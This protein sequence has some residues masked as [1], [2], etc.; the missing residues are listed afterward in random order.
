MLIS[1]ARI[2]NIVSSIRISNPFLEHEFLHK[3]DTKYLY[4]SSV[5]YSTFKRQII[6]RVVRYK[7]HQKIYII[8]TNTERNNS[9]AEQD[10]YKSACPVLTLQHSTFQDKHSILAV[11]FYLCFCGPASVPLFR[12]IP[13][14]L[15]IC[16]LACY[17]ID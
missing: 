2:S 1:I 9:F 12:K 3:V 13:L 10:I 16:P 14:C 8:I 6:Y 4:I 7:A 5:S 11:S 15:K 17:I